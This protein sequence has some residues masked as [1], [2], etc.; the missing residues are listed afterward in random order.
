MGS[1]ATRTRKLRSAKKRLA[2]LGQDIFPRERQTPQALA[3][4]HKL[5]IEKW[6]PIL[7]AANIKID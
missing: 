4:F 7:K 6:W 3:S 1:S 2:E 5:Q